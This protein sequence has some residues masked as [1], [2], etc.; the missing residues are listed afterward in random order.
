[1]WAHCGWVWVTQTHTTPIP[2]V[3]GGW[4]KQAP[5]A[6]FLWWIHEFSVDKP[7]EGLSIDPTWLLNSCYLCGFSVGNWEANL[8]T[9]NQHRPPPVWA[10]LSIF[11]SFGYRLTEGHRFICSAHFQLTLFAVL[12]VLHL[13][14][15]HGAYMWPAFHDGIAVSVG[16][17]F[18]PH[19]PPWTHCTSI[20]INNM[21]NLFAGSPTVPPVITKC[22]GQRCQQQQPAGHAA[23]NR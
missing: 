20:N 14:P 16:S 12:L 9:R 3:K 17:I 5:A 22:L 4:P 19:W 21:V 18:R 1:M 11:A 6:L 23:Y 7:K 8:P 2:G 15:N 10:K 13:S